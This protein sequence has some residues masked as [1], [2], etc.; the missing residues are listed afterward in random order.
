MLGTFYTGMSFRWTALH[1]FCYASMFITRTAIRL[2]AVTCLAV[3]AQHAH[4]QE[5]PL[6][7]GLPI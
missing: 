2:P 6:P 1:L 7:Q 3:V 4:K 5:L